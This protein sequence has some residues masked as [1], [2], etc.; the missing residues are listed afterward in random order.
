[1][2]SMVKEIHSSV[3]PVRSII[4]VA[5]LWILQ[6][7]GRFV[8]GY[9]SATTPGGLLDVEVSPI[10]IQIIN[11]MFFLLGILGFIKRRGWV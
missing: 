2:R 3:R 6:S 10:T 8:F 4:F 7:V 1:M 11:T 5:L 9:L